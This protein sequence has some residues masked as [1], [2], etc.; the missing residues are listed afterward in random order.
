MFH[1]YELTPEPINWLNPQI[2]LPGF[3][4]RV[5]FAYGLIG[6]QGEQ[7]GDLRGKSRID[8]IAREVGLNERFSIAIREQGHAVE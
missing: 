3:S 4:D 5:A 8:I 2:V 7:F 6:E 1:T